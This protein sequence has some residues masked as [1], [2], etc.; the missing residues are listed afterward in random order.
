MKKILIIGIIG[1]VAIGIAGYVFR[2]KIAGPFS[3]LE[4]R[5]GINV[6]DDTLA[7]NSDTQIYKNGVTITTMGRIEGI[8]TKSSKT[9]PNGLPK[10]TLEMSENFKGL[11]EFNGEK[12]ESIIGDYEKDL[13]CETLIKIKTDSKISH[14]GFTCFTPDD[15]DNLEKN[16][17][18]GAETLVNCTEVKDSL[19]TNN[20]ILLSVHVSADEATTAI[21]WVDSSGKTNAIPLQF[22]LYSG[23][24]S[25]DKGHAVESIDSKVID[26]GSKKSAVVEVKN[27]GKTIE[28]PKP[29]VTD[30]KTGEEISEEISN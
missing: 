18:D 12:I 27:Y 25:D 14:I 15:I 29:K 13:P 6:G 7:V 11:G 1:V 21:Y 23:K 9:I 8:G 20:E 19:D 26:S 16:I 5:M 3:T 22:S 17:K 2:A 30:A 4:R 24:A 28:S 10:T